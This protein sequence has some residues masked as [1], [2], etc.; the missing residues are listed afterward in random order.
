MS[1]PTVICG[2]TGICRAAWTPS[3][4]GRGGAGPSDIDEAGIV[5]GTLEAPPDQRFNATA[6]PFKW[7]FTA[8]DLDDLLARIDA[9]EHPEPEHPE[10]STDSPLTQQAA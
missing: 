4:T 6:A 2:G 9:H 1:R 7:T 3:Q 5:V 8:D 10:H